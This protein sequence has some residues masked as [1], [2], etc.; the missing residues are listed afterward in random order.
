MGPSFTTHDGWVGLGCG[1]KDRDVSR[2]KSIEV[3]RKPSCHVIG[4]S[5]ERQKAPWDYTCS[6]VPIYL[7]IPCILTRVTREYGSNIAA[8]QQNS[9]PM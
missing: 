4:I 5:A 9:I 2:R 7:V 3:W 1:V 6:L 8:S